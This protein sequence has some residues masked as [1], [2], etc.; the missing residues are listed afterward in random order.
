MGSLDDTMGGTLDDLVLDFD[1]T[2]TDLGDG[3]ASS[4]SL[5]FLDDDDVGLYRVGADGLGFAANGSK[6]ASLDTNGITLE[7]DNW[8]AL[9][10]NDDWRW[11][12]DS[13]NTRIELTDGT[14]DV[15][16]VDDGTTT[17]DFQGSI[18]I[19]NDLDHD[20]SNIGFFGTAPTSQTNAYSTSNV[21]TDRSFNADS[22]TTDELADVLGTLISDLQGYGLLG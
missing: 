14:N 6:Q 10:S 8:L 9:G 21:T 2:A 3:T 5:A 4:P 1:V 20:G 17:V 13:T 7:D 22:T 15:L 12:Y 18:T 16:R 11:Q 19:S